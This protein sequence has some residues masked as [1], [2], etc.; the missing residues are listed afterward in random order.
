MSD[1]DNESYTSDH[2]E[3]IDK[4][5]ES[6]EFYKEMKK[7]KPIGLKNHTGR[8]LP[9]K[10]KRIMSEKQL[11]NLKKA[12]LIAHAKL[13]DK[14]K[15]SQLMKKKEQELKILKKLEKNITVD[16]KIKDLQN[17]I[18]VEK[19]Q[20]EIIYKVKPKPKKK[21]IV[22]VSDNESEEE[23]IY[24]VKPQAESRRIYER[25]QPKP[26][27]KQPVEP[28]FEA[29]KY[30]LDFLEEVEKQK[31]QTEDMLVQKR[32]NDKIEAIKKEYLMNS[33]FHA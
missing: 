2:D 19:E 17:K 15:E 26:Q 8:D 27:A 20:E 14:K 6:N 28:Q 33:V 18:T 21:K 22:Y 30:T 5:I 4:S 13:K 25:K 11:E 31:K 29:E 24:K 7:E 3:N 9:V 1:S 12:R 16:K 32:Y 23:I 10:P